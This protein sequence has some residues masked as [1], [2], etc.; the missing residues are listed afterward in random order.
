MLPHEVFLSLSGFFSFLNTENL[1]WF[2]YAGIS[3]NTATT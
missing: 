1:S 3:E 2:P